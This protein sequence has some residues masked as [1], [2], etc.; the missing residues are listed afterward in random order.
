MALAQWVNRTFRHTEPR[1]E[2]TDGLR[3]HA[4]RLL[5]TT[6]IGGVVLAHTHVPAVHT[7]PEGTYLNPGAWH[8]QHNFGLLDAQ[9][10][11]LHQWN[12]SR[13]RAIEQA[14]L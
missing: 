1:A 13:T 8:R 5:R 2:V 11:R 7:W 3:D 9:G 4:R 6:S 14:S 12:G 10:F